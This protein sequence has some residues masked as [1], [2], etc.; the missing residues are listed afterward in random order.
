MLSPKSIIP[1][2]FVNFYC[3]YR[4]DVIR[5]LN[6]SMKRNKLRVVVMMLLQPLVFILLVGRKEYLDLL[7]VNKRICFNCY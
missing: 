3:F 2:Y 1:T 5:C 7:K 6:K 4:I